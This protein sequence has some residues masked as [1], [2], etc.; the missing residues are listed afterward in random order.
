MSAIVYDLNQLYRQTFGSKPFVIQGFNEQVT[1]IKGSPLVAD[2][3]G[4]EIWLPVRFVNLDSAVFGQSELLLP[5]TV[6]DIDLRKTIVKTSLA[7]RRGTVKE[8][9]SIDDY[10]ITL[11]GFL[12]DEDRVWPE[13]EIELLNKLWNLNEAIEFDNALTNAFLESD[14]R[15]VIEELKFPA[16]ENG[17]KH[18]RPFS[19][20]LESD[21]VFTLDV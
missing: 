9:Y 12:I 15:V 10:V 4:K 7:E 14:T 6:I 13:Q 2:F 21:S 3:L 1:Q 11:K 5:H 16:V 17:M 18:I 19:M 8:L 20:K